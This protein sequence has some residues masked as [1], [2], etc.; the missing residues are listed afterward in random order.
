L[1][2][3]VVLGG[4]PVQ[5]RVTTRYKCL[6]CSRDVRRTGGVVSHRSHVSTRACGPLV[7]MHHLPCLAGSET[8]HRDAQVGIYVPYGYIIYATCCMRLPAE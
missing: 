3:M 7:A 2:Q 4:Y 5:M 6:F 8:L 1:Y